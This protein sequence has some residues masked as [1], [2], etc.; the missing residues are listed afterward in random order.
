MAPSKM[1]EKTEQNGSSDSDVDALIGRFESMRVGGGRGGR[2]TDSNAMQSGAMEADRAGQ[3]IG[4]PARGH[5]TGGNDTSEPAG[6]DGGAA[7]ASRDR[8]PQGELSDRPRGGGRRQRRR[9]NRRPAAG[10]SSSAAVTTT[11]GVTVA[12]GGGPSADGGRGVRKP[13]GRPAQFA[14]GWAPSA[15]RVTLSTCKKSQRRVTFARYAQALSADGRP[16]YEPVNWAPSVLRVA[17]MS[18]R[19]VVECRVSFDRDAQPTSARRRQS[20]EPANRA[21]F[22]PHAAAG[23]GR[24]D[25][26]NV[27]RTVDGRGGGDRAVGGR[28][29][30]GNVG[31]H[32]GPRVVAKS[33]F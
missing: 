6:A 22:V 4:R 7:T 11:T 25:R 16:S 17:S 32:G 5:G 29:G 9:R 33:C 24:R 20:R 14:D 8:K 13:A 21:P 10:V 1:N 27:D 19:P 23:G 12:A 2:S 18:R 15:L 3:L 28:G 30:G 31:G 26:E